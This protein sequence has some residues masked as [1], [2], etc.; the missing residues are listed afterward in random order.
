M[1]IADIHLVNLHFVDAVK[2]CIP[3]SEYFCKFMKEKKALL[4]PQKV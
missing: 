3:Q 1:T 4:K 2:W